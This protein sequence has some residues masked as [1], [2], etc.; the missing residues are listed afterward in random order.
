MRCR[1][2]AAGGYSDRSGKTFNYGDVGEFP[3]HVAVK[4]IGYRILE[5]APEPKREAP[6]VAPPE[7]TA[8][9]VSKPT[10]KPAQKKKSGQEGTN[11]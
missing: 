2:I 9:S 4:L 10:P 11:S 1:V 5:P 3:D 7:N 8:K 6:V